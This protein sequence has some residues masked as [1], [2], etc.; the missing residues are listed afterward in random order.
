MPKVISNTSYFQGNDLKKNQNISID[1]AIISDIIKSSNRENGQSLVVPGLIDLQIY[2]AGGRLFSADPTVE[3][4]TIMEDDL[5]KKGTTGFLACMATNS[6]EVFNECIKVAKEHRSAAKNCLGLHLEGPFLNPKRLGA[7]VPAFV[8]K[9]SLDEV[10]KLIDF[11]DGV[12]KMMTIAPELQDEGVIEYLLDNG[13]VISLGHSNATFEE[14]TAAYNKGIQTTTHLFNAMS[15]IHHR[16]PGIPTAVFNHNKAM[17][18]IIADGQHVDFEVIKFAQKILKERLFLITDAVT[19]CSTGP[20]QHIE[21]ENKFV[22]PDGTLSGSSLTMLEAVKNCVLH[23]GIALNDAIKMG[24]LY[25]AKLIGIENLTA[26]I[27]IGHQANLL[28]IDDNL[29]LKEVVFKG[30]TI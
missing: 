6:P 10:K 5:L 23:C 17:A 16:E 11:G 8:R 20:Y 13:V 22:M 26:S 15:P 24:T 25:P 18:S 4:L 2:G 12:I 21:K 1:G 30:E 28:I 19:A 14:A 29:N 3:S 9:A 27:E 7:H